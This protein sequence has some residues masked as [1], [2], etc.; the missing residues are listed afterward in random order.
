M[1]KV[2]ATFDHEMFATLSQTL[3][4][5]HFIDLSTIED[6]TKRLYYQQLAAHNHWSLRELRR[7]QDA[8][9]FERSLLAA[10]P[11][12]EIVAAL[13]SSNPTAN[14]EVMLKSSYVVDFLG[15]RG[16]Y[17]EKDL[18]TAIIT[19]LERFI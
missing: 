5:S 3:S 12:D 2:A 1:V 11:E 10:R 18:E 13:T 9:D 16:C 8:M 14:P 7:H 19:Q 6:E 17:S 15:L 4:W